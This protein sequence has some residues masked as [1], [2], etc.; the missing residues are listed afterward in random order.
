MLS[1]LSLYITTL[2]V[3]ASFNKWQLIDAGR[4]DKHTDDLTENPDF[5][6]F[7][8]KPGES[9]SQVPPNW[10]WKTVLVDDLC[11]DNPYVRNQADSK[12]RN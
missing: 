9:G 8:P 11:S 12:F 7:P 2:I 1:F 6:P 4:D 3:V 10:K 5:G